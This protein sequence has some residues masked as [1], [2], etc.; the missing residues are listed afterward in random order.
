MTTTLDVERRLRLPAPDEPAVLPPLLLPTAAQTR[1]GAAVRFRGPMVRP[2]DA[3]LVYAL[4]ALVLLMLAVIVVGALRLLDRSHD[5]LADTCQGPAP[6]E[7]DCIIMAI[8]AGWHELAAGSYFPG[9][10]TEAASGLAYERVEHVLANVELQGCGQPGGA[11]P[12]AIETGGVSTIP[13]ETADP[14]LFCLR[15]APLPEHGIRIETMRGS[16]T[17]GVVGEDGPA[18]PDTSEP[19]IE[20]GWTEVV[21]GRPARLTV[22]AGTGAPGA[23]AET[24]TWDVLFPASIDR[25]LRIRADIAG[26]DVEAGRRSVQEFVDSIAFQA[27]GP[28]LDPSAEADVLRVTLDRLERDYSDLYGCFPREPGERP[29]TI[30]SGFAA[31]LSAPTGVRCRAAMSE[32]RAELWRI[33]LDVSWDAGDGYPADTLHTE[34]FVTGP[35]AIQS[36]GYV[37]ARSGRTDPIGGVDGLLPNSGHT[38]PPPL[39]GPLDLPPGSLVRM[40]WPGE[41][42]AGELPSAGPAEDAMAPSLVGIHLYVIAGPAVVGGEEWYRVQGN[43]DLGIAWARGARDARPLLELVDPACPVGPLGAADI[44]RLIPGERLVCFGS[45][46]LSIE[47]AVLATGE[48]TPMLPDGCGLENGLSGPCPTG[49][50]EP[51]WLTVPTTWFLYGEGG[52]LGP[53]RPVPVWL[54]PGLA[55]PDGAP[56]RVAGHF[57]DPG[58][59]GCGWPPMGSSGLDPAADL[60]I[61]EL[62][63]RE[64]F[65]VTGFEAASAH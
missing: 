56:V 9:D 62:L 54:A 12:T 22:L 24:R 19:T 8:P 11:I 37:T 65:V 27:A 35:G 43:P 57:D 46:E 29:A 47:P 53:V 10:F 6:A 32:S 25:L 40:L 18:E 55:A 14:N 52:A 61:Q 49:P 16:R 26:P 30:S 50:G 41:W 59:R 21:A 36:G 31:P 44:A 4:V 58:A 42:P 23:P 51:G 20:A 13:R 38:L 7:A 60:A 48:M 64:R 2:Q 3:R 34:F 15:T 17:N 39:A 1:R 45:R 5:S 28:T 63:C 33:V